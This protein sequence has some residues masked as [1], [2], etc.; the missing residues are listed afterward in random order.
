M[1]QVSSKSPPAAIGEKYLLV[2]RVN[3]DPIVDEIP[4][5]C[6]E[7]QFTYGVSPRAL[8]SREY[9]ELL[10]HRGRGFAP[11][12]AA[13]LPVPCRRALQKA[14]GSLITLRVIENP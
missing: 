1:C 7:R 8:T 5:L 9:I 6:A 4:A 2:S 11:V 3:V 13:S 14:S 10:S 12:R